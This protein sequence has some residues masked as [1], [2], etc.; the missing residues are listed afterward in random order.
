MTLQEWPEE[1][2]LSPDK[3]MLTLHFSD[4]ASG[5][6]AAE[7]LRVES[8]SAEVQGHAP[9]EKRLIGGKKSVLITGL[10]PVG[11]YAVRIQFSDGHD[12]GL[13]TWPYLK[14]LIVEREELWGAYL[15][16]L[17]EAGLSR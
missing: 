16:K 15:K 4:G 14:R 17:D 11:N 8:P 7:Y 9:D 10:E 2:R 6:L 5:S 1:I 3:T 12:S 13:F